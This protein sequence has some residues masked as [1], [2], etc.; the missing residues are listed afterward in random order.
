MVLS[1]GGHGKTKEILYA[2]K[3]CVLNLPC[4]F[5]GSC[6]CFKKKNISPYTNQID[7]FFDRFVLLFGCKTKETTGFLNF[8]SK[9]IELLTDCHH[10]AALTKQN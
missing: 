7:G 2:R 6:N 5:F 10:L 8:D 4:S 3:P 1:K 9:V